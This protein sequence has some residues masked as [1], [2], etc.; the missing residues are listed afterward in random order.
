MK[1]KIIF[2]F[3]NIVILLS[4]L[5]IFFMPLFILG[6]E[7]AA[8]F[9]QKSWYLP[10]LFLLVVGGI[11][12]YFLFN[13]KLFT[14]LEQEDWEGVITFTE[15]RLYRRERI[16]R[17]G[18]RVLINAYLLKNRLDDINRLEE[19]LK[20]KKPR[21]H[22]FFV[23]PLG[24]PKLL[25]TDAEALEFYYGPL[26]G[27]RRNDRDWFQFLYAFALLMQQ[28]RDEAAR[29]F[30]AVFSLDPSPVVLIL[31]LYSLEP[32]GREDDRIASLVSEKSGTLKRRYSR[33]A[34]ERDVRKSREQLLPV[35]LGKMINDAI[36]WLYPEDAPAEQ[37][38]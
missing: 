35:I 36:A 2:I 25:R 20:E 13:W 37:A 17:L 23:L 38:E 33:A 16:G 34:L 18:V 14:C 24:I 28:R 30:E 1:F 8:S 32:F 7:Y 19:W 12:S 22:S 5:V 6:G 27:E 11:D 4:F 15:E 9:W 3:F 10:L 29:E 31:A 21:L 26:R